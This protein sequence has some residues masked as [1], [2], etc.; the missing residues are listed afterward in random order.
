VP[1]F[2]GSEGRYTALATWPPPSPRHSRG[3]S[4]GDAPGPFLGRGIAAHGAPPTFGEKAIP[5][6]SLNHHSRIPWSEAEVE[7]QIAR[8]I[9][10]FLRIGGLR[11]AARS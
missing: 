8:A 6:A 4:H 2:R 5:Q 7:G 10:C 9:G 3:T 11:V 1:R